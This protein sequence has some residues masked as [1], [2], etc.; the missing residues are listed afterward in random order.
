MDTVVCLTLAKWETVSGSSGAISRR[1]RA[2][3]VQAN[4]GP[5]QRTT[6]LRRLSQMCYLYVRF[7]PVA[8][9]TDQDERRIGWAGNAC[10]EA[11]YRLSRRDLE[12]RQRQHQRLALQIAVRADRGDGL[13]QRLYY[14]TGVGTKFGQVLRGGMFG[15]GLN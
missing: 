8:V 9:R 3:S 13:E 10:Q 12:H 4:E 15:Y 11:G 5:P 1:H 2:S 7:R 14:S 6:R